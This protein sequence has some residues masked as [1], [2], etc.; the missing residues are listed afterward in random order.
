[1]SPSELDLRFA[2]IRELAVSAGRLTLKHFQQ[3][4]LEVEKKEDQSPVTVADKEAEQ[5][6][7]K[8]ILQQ[9]PNDAVLGE[10]FGET[11]GTSGFRWILDPIDGTKSFISGVPLY[12][13]RGGRWSCR[14]GSGLHPRSG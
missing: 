10:E 8:E 13:R 12:G 5:W 9:F 6:L 2:S 7:R 1:M 3:R 11:P 14:D 4:E